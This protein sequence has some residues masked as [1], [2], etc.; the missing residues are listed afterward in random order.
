MARLLDRKVPHFG[1]GP[2][3]S[4]PP[5]RK[6]PNWEGSHP[7]R[8]GQRQNPI[9]HWPRQ[10]GGKP[11]PPPKAGNQMGSE[12]AGGGRVTARRGGSAHWRRRLC[13]QQ[14]KRVKTEMGRLAG[15]WEALPGLRHKGRPCSPS[16]CRAGGRQKEAL[17]PG[18]AALAGPSLRGRDGQTRPGDS[19][20][21][22][23]LGK[24][25]DKTSPW[26]G[27]WAVQEES[28]PH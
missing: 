18:S 25:Q 5:Q 8:P 2:P 23:S 24:P 4:S 27:T 16:H 21:I 17:V 14:R 11:P 26:S 22:R 9:H 10:M 1:A 12:W 6:R 13:C 15:G 3:C 20:P 19:S 28:P 7:G